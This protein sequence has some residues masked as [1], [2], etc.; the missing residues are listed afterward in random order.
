MNILA[1]HIDRDGDGKNCLRLFNE[2]LEHC[3]SLLPCGIDS[4]GL[5]TSWDV[6]TPDGEVQYC[7]VDNDLVDTLVTHMGG[8]NRIK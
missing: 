6:A 5:V 1:S 7:G 4:E 3:L 2:E 8:W